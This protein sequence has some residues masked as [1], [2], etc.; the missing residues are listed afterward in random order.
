MPRLNLAMLNLKRGNYKTAHSALKHC[1]RVVVDEERQLLLGSVYVAL[2]MAVAGLKDW[3][4][5]DRY[6]AAAE[7]EIAKHGFAERDCAWAAERSY[8]LARRGGQEERA[9]RAAKFALAQYRSLEDTTGVVR[10]QG[11]LQS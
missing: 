11:Y 7:G 8:E 10:I 5:F 9:T 3:S 2:M 6:A 4:A 1:K